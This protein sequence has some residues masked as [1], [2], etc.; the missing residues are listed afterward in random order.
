MEL[1]GGMGSKIYVIT[2]VSFSVL[3]ILIFHVIFS[4]FRFATGYICLQWYTYVIVYTIC[5]CLFY[6]D[7]NYLLVYHCSRIKNSGIF[8]F[9]GPKTEERAWGCTKISKG[10]FWLFKAGFAK[11]CTTTPYGEG[12]EQK[13]LLCYAHFYANQQSSLGHACGWKI[14]CWSW[15]KWH[16]ESLLILRVTLP[17][18]NQRIWYYL[19]KFP[20]CNN[21]KSGSA[22]FCFTYLV[23]FKKISWKVVT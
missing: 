3:L 5:P 8:T 18:F 22:F 16:G 1:F 12:E 21:L 15:D 7:F 14:F 23:P 17:L 9:T 2:N 6:A 13:S 10:C 4:I 20:F 11:S 19:A